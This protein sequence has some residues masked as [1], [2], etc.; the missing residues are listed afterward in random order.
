M[1][2][3]QQRLTTIFA[4]LG[5]ALWTREEKAVPW[6]NTLAPDQTTW[7]IGYDVTDE[8][9][10]FVLM[11]QDEPDS[12]ILPLDVLLDDSAYDD[13]RADGELDRAQKNRARK[14][15][16]AFVDYLIP[17]VPL[18]TDDLAPVTL[19]FKRVNSG[20][21]SMGDFDMVRALSWTGDFDLETVL[22]EKIKPRLEELGWESLDRGTLL[23]IIATSYGMP[24]GEIEWEKL[25]T[26][27]KTNPDNFTA[28]SDSLTWAIALLREIGFAGPK[29]LPYSSILLFAARVWHDTKG[30]LSPEKRQRLQTWLVEAAVTERFGAAPPHIV[31]AAWRELRNV[32]DG[33]PIQNQRSKPRV[34]TASHGVNFRWARSMMTTAVLAGHSPRAS[35][36]TMIY[37][38]SIRVGFS[39]KDWYRKLLQSDENKNALFLSAANRVVCDPADLENLKTTLQSPSCDSDLLESHAITSEA[40]AFLL[41]GDKIAFLKARFLRIV[42]LENEWLARHGSD[43]I[44]RLQEPTNAEF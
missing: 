36:G 3:G 15:R 20:G 13:W 41:G 34:A 4:A 6:Q 2:D 10:Q 22:E 35:D 5:P 39:G 37:E 42:A 16:S 18:A 38:S 44:I 43:L 24:P 21:T 1:V 7:S 11:G 29:T 27:I 23:K 31:N 14:V 30:V 25:S 26:A 28:I 8:D 17:V 12:K 9:G 40:H 32:M 33:Q 19:T